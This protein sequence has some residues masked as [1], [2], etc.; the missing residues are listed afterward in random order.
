MV[1]LKNHSV[2]YDC[3]PV[4]LVFLKKNEE[5]PS[6]ILKRAQIPSFPPTSRVPELR[7]GPGPAGANQQ[8]VGAPPRPRAGGG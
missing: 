2:F 8:K 3:F 5:L 4:D 6:P 1:D 7:P